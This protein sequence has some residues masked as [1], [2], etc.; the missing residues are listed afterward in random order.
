MKIVEKK[1]PGCGANLKFGENDT[2]V[3]CEYCGKELYIQR[4]EKKY[5]K[6]DD[7]HLADAYKFVDEFGKPIAKGIAVVQIIMFIIFGLIFVSAF[8]FFIFIATSMFSDTNDD[9]IFKLMQSANNNENMVNYVKT[10]SDI[11]DVTL[12]T[13]YDASKSSLFHWDNRGYTVGA[14]SP[15]GSY[16]L[17]SND[18][19]ENF[20]YTVMKHTYT[21]RKTKKTIDL[22]AAVKYSNLILTDNN[23]IEHTFKGTSI[24]QDIDLDDDTFNYAEGFESVEKLYNYELRNKKNNYKIYASEGLYMES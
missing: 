1:C 4:D 16:L 15:V 18:G 21:N 9:N 23:V 2:N 3:K 12:E 17:V 14:W 22:Y 20:L 5:E 24:S 7:T 10:L 11:D 8:A 6:F 19:G 13:F